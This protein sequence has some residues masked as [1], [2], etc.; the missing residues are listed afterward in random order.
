[1]KRENM[2]FEDA[3][4]ETCWELDYLHAPASFEEGETVTVFTAIPDREQRACL[5]FPFVWIEKEDSPCG[6]QCELYD[7]RNG[8]SGACR[9]LTHGYTKGNQV[10]FR[11]EAGEWKD[12]K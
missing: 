3:N 7:P 8:R 11:L 6:R 9:S 5:K 2:Y 4:A 10:T 12:A 1:M